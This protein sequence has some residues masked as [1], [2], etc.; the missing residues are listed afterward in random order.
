MSAV[1]AEWTVPPVLIVSLDI[2][3]R[4]V[5]RAMRS[6][7]PILTPVFCTAFRVL[8]LAE[9]T[10][11]NNVRI[12]SMILVIFACLLNALPNRWLKTAAK[13]IQRARSPKSQSSITKPS[14]LLSKAASATQGTTGSTTTTQVNPSAPRASLAVPSTGSTS[15]P[16]S[17]T[18][19]QLNPTGGAAS[20]MRSRL[21]SVLMRAS[22]N[23]MGD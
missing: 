22:A 19:A 14:S 2:S 15:R 6:V 11:F 18:N 10:Y 13:F 9:D 5:P 16:N 23:V 8:C 20:K 3:Q 12:V 7:Q 17:A 4:K 1:C 21:S